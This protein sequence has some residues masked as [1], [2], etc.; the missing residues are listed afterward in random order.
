MNRY[1]LLGTDQTRW[2]LMLHNMLRKDDTLCHHDHPWNFWTYVLCGGYEEEV[3][4]PN[5]TVETRM[6]TPG[7]ILFRPAEHAH[8]IKSLPA[9][10]CWT[11]V[12]RTKRVRDWGFHSPVGW[13]WHTTFIR[14]YEKAAHWCDS[15]ITN[16]E[17]HRTQIKAASR[18]EFR[19]S[20]GKATQEEKSASVARGRGEAGDTQP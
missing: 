7:T 8:C 10:H 6:N 20:G 12:F 4:L 18:S 14:L 9:G 1:W 3:A 17:R 11:L 19:R 5:G 15:G 13:V 16:Y 2:A